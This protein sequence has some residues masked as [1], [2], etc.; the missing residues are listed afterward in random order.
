M[1]LTEVLGV[2]LGVVL[3]A[4]MGAISWLV[5]GV[6][7]HGHE[8][9]AIRSATEQKDQ[10]RDELRALMHDVST[11]VDSSH[12]DV[13]RLCERTEWLMR[14]HDRHERFLESVRTGTD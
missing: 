5:R 1:E 10:A 3:A 7:H 8:I 9:A 2:A 13:K 11:K 14:G 12:S 6:I 4:I